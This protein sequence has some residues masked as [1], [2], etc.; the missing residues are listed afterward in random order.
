M[1]VSHPSWGEGLVIDSR[2]QDDD[3]RVDVFFDSVGFK[4]LAASLA[5][6][7]VIK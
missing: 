4:R 7:E 5:N 1:R 6:L 2:V 3:E